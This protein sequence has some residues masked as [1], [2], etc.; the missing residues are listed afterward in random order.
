M[1]KRTC[2]E[3]ITAG[4]FS[5]QF[6]NTNRKMELAGHYHFARVYFEFETTG[7]V[8]FPSFEHTHAEIRDRLLE[9]TE[10]PFRDSTNEDVLRQLF[11]FF[12]QLDLEEVKKYDAQFRLAAMEL[13][14]RGVPDRIGHADAF[15]VYKIRG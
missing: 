12:E 8:G 13:H 10:K 11:E 9:R 15:T 6:C 7:D 5:I 14:V 4:P 3:S 2:K 1:P